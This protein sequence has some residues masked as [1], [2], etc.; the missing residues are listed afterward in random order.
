MSPVSPNMKIQGKHLS[1]LSP[2][3]KLHV[4][5]YLESCDSCLGTYERVSVPKGHKMGKGVIWAV[6]GKEIYQTIQ[7]GVSMSRSERV[8]VN[9]RFMRL[10]EKELP[11]KHIYMAGTPQD[12]NFPFGLEKRLVSYGLVLD[13]K[14]ARKCIQT[15][16][17]KILAYRQGRK[18]GSQQD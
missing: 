7:D 3:V 5:E 18:C 16:I 11:V 2:T 6:K 13:S 4:E 17:N 10:A 1:T 12:Y 8:R 15:Q 14:S 9:A